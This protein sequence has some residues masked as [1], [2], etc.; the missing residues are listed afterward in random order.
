MSEEIDGLI[1]DK[2]AELAPFRVRMEKLREQ[3]K[4]ETAV[5]AREWYRKTAK[6]YVSKYPEVALRLTEERI[7]AMKAGVNDLARDAP[8]IVEGEL[9]NPTLW[10][11]LEPHLHDSVEKYLQVADKYPEVLDR[12]VRRVLGQLGVVLEKFGFNV[13]ASV[14]AGTYREFWFE[15]I[16]S[17]KTVPCYPHLLAWT[18]NMQETIRQYD[19]QYVEASEI[20][21]EIQRLKGE[22]KKLEALSRWDSI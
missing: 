12:A 13:T 4:D 16:D 19:A 17:R 15:H 11:H 8:R 18:D 3:F 1:A 9:D 7:A 20:Y 22:K 21:G 10:W 6:D 14:S 5:F 2:E